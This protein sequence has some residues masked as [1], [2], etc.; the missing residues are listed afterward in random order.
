[1]EYH[2]LHGTSD[3]VEFTLRV[4]AWVGVGIGMDALDILRREVYVE[5][6]GLS[7]AGLSIT[8]LARTSYVGSVFKR[9]DRTIYD[10]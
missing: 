10:A 7:P 5:G 2:V 3:V 9:L 6:C 8:V 1:M 4:L